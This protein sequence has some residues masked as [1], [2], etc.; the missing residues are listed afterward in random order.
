M[1]LLICAGHAAAQS[2][3]SPAVIVA[4]TDTLTSRDA[5]AILVRSPV[6][7]EDV[8]ILKRA[9]AS[10]EI[11]GGA[12]ALLD[13]FRAHSPTPTSVV[14]ATVQG[15]A[16]RQ[17]LANARLAVLTATLRRLAEQPTVRIG[18]LGQGQWVRLTDTNSAP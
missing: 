5:R 12:L 16:P 10:A 13:Q 11:L 3:R 17:A 4:I 7:N 9:T 8:I 15:T 18:N 14:V 6:K 1:P 2:T